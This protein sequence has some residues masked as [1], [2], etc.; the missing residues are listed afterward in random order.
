MSTPLGI[1]ERIKIEK[2][3]TSNIIEFSFG[4]N[5]GSIVGTGK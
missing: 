2:R 1:F 3:N 5:V 4:R